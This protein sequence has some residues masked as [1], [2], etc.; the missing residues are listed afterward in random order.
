MTNKHT[1]KI[2]KSQKVKSTLEMAFDGTLYSVNSC[3]NRTISG[4]SPLILNYRHTKKK[5]TLID[6]SWTKGLMGRLNIKRT[7]Q[8]LLNRLE[9]PALN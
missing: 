1:L 3:I 5:K 6:C 8:S 7:L 4:C 2:R 9:R